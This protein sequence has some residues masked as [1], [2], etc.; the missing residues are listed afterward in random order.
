M[1]HAFFIILSVFSPLILR[2]GFSF[3][4]IH[5]GMYSYINNIYYL[6]KKYWATSLNLS[7]QLFSV[8]LPKLY[9]IKHLAMHFTNIWERMGRSKELI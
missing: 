3:V 7:L 9:K 8:P 2:H 6:D 4:E 5:D 1:W